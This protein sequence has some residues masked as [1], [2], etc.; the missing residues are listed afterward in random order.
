LDTQL[1]HRLT[2]AII[3]VA[4]A[5]LFVP[6]LLTGPRPGG[7][8]AGATISPPPSEPRPG[9]TADG[10]PVRSYD[11]DLTDAAARPASARTATAPMAAPP[12][13]DGT[14]THTD[15]STGAAPASGNVPDAIKP[16]NAARVAAA[17]ASPPA[18]AGPTVATRAPGF[19]V[20]L[21]SFAARD[22]AEHLAT[23]LRARRFAAFVSPVN[24]DG[25]RLYRVRVGPL[26]D[27]PA[28]EVLQSRLAGLGRNGT[29][30]TE[31]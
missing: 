26:S 22:T 27:R 12:P 7:A 9:A 21:G 2:G 10:A 19:A 11:I 1:K 20:Q 4:L 16:D 14:G 25:R 13:A 17:P 6:E 18:A 28:A 24:V 15:A 5:V 31:P 3:L 29:V 30:V 8:G 23:D